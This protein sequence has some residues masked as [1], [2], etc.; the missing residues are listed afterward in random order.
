[1][2]NATKAAVMTNGVTSPFFDL[3]RG[4][5]Q[6]CPLLPLLFTIALEPL[7]IAIR[8]NPSISGVIGGGSEHK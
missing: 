6:G 2:Y 1:M 4:T 8:T 3:A 5:R 7:A